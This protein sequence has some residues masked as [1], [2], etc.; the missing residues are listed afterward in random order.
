MTKKTRR[1]LPKGQRPTSGSYRGVF[2]HGTGCSCRT[3]RRLSEQGRA[4]NPGMEVGLTPVRTLAI[5]HDKCPVCKCCP[6]VPELGACQECADA[7]GLISEQR[8]A[9]IRSDEGGRDAD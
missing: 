6:I 3:C 8:A 9:Q 2:E 4:R 5:D 7:Q 1:I